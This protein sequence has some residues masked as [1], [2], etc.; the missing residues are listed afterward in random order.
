MRVDGNQGGAPNYF[1]NSFGGPEPV[2]TG[3]YV[4]LISVF[5][6]LLSEVEIILNKSIAVSLVVLSIY[7]SFFMC[8]SPSI[9][10]LSFLPL[11]PNLIFYC[12]VSYTISHS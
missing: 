5:F 2:P 6:L 10:L 3:K 1:P 11:S 7:I 8:Y 9:S 4:F 12:D